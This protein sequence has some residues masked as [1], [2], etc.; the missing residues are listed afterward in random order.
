M[1]KLNKRAKYNRVSLFDIVLT[2]IMIAFMATIILP[3]VHVIAVSLSDAVM[4]MGNQVSFWP[5]GFTIYTYKTMLSTGNFMQAY[6][7]T[8]FVTVVGTAL[9]LLLTATC[10]YALS[11]RAIVGHTFFSLM[12]TF[13]LFFNGG[14]IPTYLNVLNLGMIDTVWS[15][16]IPACLNTWNMI[17]MRSFFVAYPSEIIESGMMDGLQDAGVFFRLVL[18]TSKAA[19]AT[20]GLYYAVSYWNAYMNAKMYIQVNTHLRPVQQLLQEMINVNPDAGGG[21]EGMLVATSV[22]Y[23]A[24]MIVITPIMCVYPFIQKYFVK[25]VMVGSVKG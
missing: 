10:A 1:A 22:R 7:V 18:P 16:I 4:V 6:G 12:I 20:I 15:L 2:I 11:R 3:F 23:A 14:V 21:E 5:K 17:I 24:I 13:T 25:G 19:L 9:S 8:I